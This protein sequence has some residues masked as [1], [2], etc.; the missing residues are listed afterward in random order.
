MSAGFSSL[1]AFWMGGYGRLQIAA[2]PSPPVTAGGGFAGETI[3]PR[4]VASLFVREK[5]DRLFAFAKITPKE[6]D[7]DEMDDDLLMLAALTS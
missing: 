6:F 4:I 3:R 7:D 1:L 2:P 5:P